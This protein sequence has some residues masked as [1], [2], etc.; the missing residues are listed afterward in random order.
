MSR[1]NSDQR[2]RDRRHDDARQ[3][4][5]AELQDDQHVNQDH[6]GSERQT[7]VAKCFV[8]DGPLAGPFEAGLVVV[9]W[10]AN[11]RAANR[12]TVWRLVIL[13]ELGDL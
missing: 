1:D 3:A 5:I 13:E 9:I 12:D 6:R 11:K 2:Q 10:R 7:H 8:R 4:E